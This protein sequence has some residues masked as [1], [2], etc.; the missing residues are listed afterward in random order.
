MRMYLC[1]VDPVDFDL[2]CAQIRHERKRLSG[3]STTSCACGPFWRRVYART[4]MLI[5]TR[6]VA[7]A[8]V[9]MQSERRDAPTAVI[10]NE[11]HFAGLVD[12]QVASAASAGINLV[13]KRDGA[14]L[15]I[16]GGS[17]GA[18]RFVGVRSASRSISVT[19]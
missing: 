5:E 13:E 1:R 3:E 17:D 18:V 11:Q 9:R 6:P 4:R 10:G 2:I 7:D 19:A 16:D 15:G 14:G 8:P 12:D